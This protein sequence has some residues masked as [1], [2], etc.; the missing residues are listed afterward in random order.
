MLPSYRAP[1]DGHPYQYAVVQ[2]AKREPVPLHA[3]VVAVQFTDKGVSFR[4]L[5][6]RQV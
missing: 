2:R 5:H 1:Y 6:V 3:L 4:Q